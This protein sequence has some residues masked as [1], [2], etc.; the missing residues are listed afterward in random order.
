M[1]KKDEYSGAGESR[2]GKGTIDE[3]PS[4]PNPRDP[5]PG[6]DSAGHSSG[7]AEQS[8]DSDV[9]RCRAGYLILLPSPPRGIT[10]PNGAQCWTTRWSVHP[11]PPREGPSG[12][13]CHRQHRFPRR[14]S[15]TGRAPSTARF[16][17]PFSPAHLLRQSWRPSSFIV[18]V[19]NPSLLPFTRSTPV[20]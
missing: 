2:M 12:S 6:G 10:C 17:L 4:S 1:V 8:N 3:N 14:H 18:T 13:L 11:S 20:P 16:A 7:D 15:N 5:S 19:M 9:P